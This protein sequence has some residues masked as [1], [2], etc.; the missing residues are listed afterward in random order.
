MNEHLVNI[1]GNRLTPLSFQ[2]KIID[3][4]IKHNNCILSMPTGSGKTIV[5]YNWAN[6]FYNMNTINDF[7]KIIFTSPLKSISNERYSELKRQ[8]PSVG[9]VTGDLEYN[10]NADVLCMTQEVFN[11]RYYKTPANVVIDEFHYIFNNPERVRSYLEPFTKLSP[12]SNIL[13]MSATINNPLH[14]SEYLTKLSNRKFEVVNSNIKLVESEYNYKGIYSYE[15]KDAIIFCFS[16]K[17][18]YRIVELL[19][20]KRSSNNNTRT[21]AELNRLAIINKVEYRKEWEFG[22]AVYH[23]K[24]LPKE[25]KFVEFL[26]RSGYVDI[27][28]ATDAIALGVNL[29]AKYVIFAELIKPHN[30]SLIKYSEFL[31]Y[32]GRAGRYGQNEIGIISFLKDSPVAKLDGKKY[33][34]EKSFLKMTKS[35]LEPLEIIPEVSYSNLLRYPKEY[36]MSAIKEFYYTQLPVNKQHYDDISLQKLVNDGYS[37][38]QHSNLVQMQYFSCS[39]DS[40]LFLEVLQHSYT[41]DWSLEINIT[42]SA[43]VTKLLFLH[44]YINCLKL[45][46]TFND[47]NHKILNSPGEYL[48]ELL[49]LI[50]YINNI[51]YSLKKLS[52]IP[53]YTSG[54]FAITNINEIVKLA[55][56]LDHTVFLGDDV[57]TN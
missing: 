26:Y 30:N 52:N 56:E 9:I 55:Y 28:V 6:I 13:V 19:K 18:I 25:K 33:N 57:Y 41:E 24:M 48:Y 17:S 15:I 37:Y 43:A 4:V 54:A 39:F 45:L 5:A 47:I 3:K 42:M 51:N 10:E 21:L 23:G 27:V 35:S 50:K 7:R 20:E 36:E 1:I 11:N 38:L 32:S 8:L 2:S 40:M 44:G 16:R 46:D 29:P 53:Y 34:L 49:I 22:I 12:K 31:Q 14:L